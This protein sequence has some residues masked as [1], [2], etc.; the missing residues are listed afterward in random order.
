M[1]IYFKKDHSA[2][3]TCRYK[4]RFITW[5]SIKQ[6]ELKYPFCGVF[7]ILHKH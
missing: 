1:N 2:A 7:E 4:N 3:I 5:S 6:A